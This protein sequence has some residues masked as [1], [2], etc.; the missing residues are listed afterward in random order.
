MEIA[1]LMPLIMLLVIGSLSLGLMLADR[2]EIQHAA[3]EGAVM[4]AQAPSDRCTTA[5]GATAAVLARPVAS[6]ACTEDGTTISVEL[7]DA[8]PLPGGARTIHVI[9]R[10]AIR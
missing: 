3:R 10:G 2:I 4:G 1:L 6:A 7:W 5:L 8:L 9:E